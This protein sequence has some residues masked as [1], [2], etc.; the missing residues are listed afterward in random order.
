MQ[1]PAV[2]MMSSSA[3]L[4]EVPEAPKPTF[5]TV[6]IIAGAV[7]FIVI[8]AAIVEQAAIRRNKRALEG[9]RVDADF[10]GETFEYDGALYNREQYYEMRLVRLS[11]GCAS[12]REM[13]KLLARAK[14]SA[15]L[16]GPQAVLYQIDVV[17]LEQLLDRLN[18][19]KPKFVKKGA[20]NS[21]DSDSQ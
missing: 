1:L 5:S 7:L 19:E 3:L 12:K 11:Q 16:G 10:A 21:E 8:L 13:E 18:R 14:R 2:L 6:W 17:A 9:C 20:E 15:G 4:P